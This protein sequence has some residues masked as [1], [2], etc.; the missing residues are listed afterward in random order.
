M[1]HHTTT[2]RSCRLNKE[3]SVRHRHAAVAVLD[4]DRVPADGDVDRGAALER[5]AAVERKRVGRLA[6]RRERRQHG[7]IAATRQSIVDRRRRNAQCSADAGRRRRCD[8]VAQVDVVHV[9][10]RR[11]RRR[12]RQLADSGTRRLA[13][14]GDRRRRLRRQIDNLRDVTAGKRCRANAR[15]AARSAAA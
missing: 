12:A 7:V 10:P 3:H 8:V 13:V 1:P 11:D 9:R 15:R 4:R 6:A 5:T 14:H 2:N